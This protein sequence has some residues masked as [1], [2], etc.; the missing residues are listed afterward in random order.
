MSM[1]LME[2]WYISVSR[3]MAEALNAADHLNGDFG[4]YPTSHPNW[5][6]ENCDD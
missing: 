1:R 6:A 4:A 3:A 2:P 5:V